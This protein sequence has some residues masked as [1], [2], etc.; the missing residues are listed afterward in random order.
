MASETDMTMIITLFLSLIVL[1]ITFGW[2]SPNIKE[3]SRLSYKVKRDC[4]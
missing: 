1:V 2:I 4:K 3:I